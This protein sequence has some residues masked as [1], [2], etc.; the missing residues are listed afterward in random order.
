MK[1]ILLTSIS[2]DTSKLGYAGVAHLLMNSVSGTD[3]MDLLEPLRTM[4]GVIIAT[5]AVGE[6][7]CYA[8]IL[9][10]DFHDFFEK[11]R[12]I[13][14]LPTLGQ[15]NFAI[16]KNNQPQWPV[17]VDEIGPYKDLIKES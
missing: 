15:L 13:Q 12:C 14:K 5:R 4:P 6:Y 16:R 11:I 2:I 3:L 10:R 7:E 8:V 9:F 1:H 17:N